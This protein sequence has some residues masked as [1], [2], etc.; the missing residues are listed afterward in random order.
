MNP[1]PFVSLNHFTLPVFRMLFCSLFLWPETERDLIRTRPLSKF[2]ALTPG[3]TNRWH[4][5]R[6]GPYAVWH[7]MSRAEDDGAG[8]RQSRGRLSRSA[9]FPRALIPRPLLA[10]PTG[11]GPP[12]SCSLRMENDV[13][14]DDGAR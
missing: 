4:L 5:G 2:L 12:P 9:T 13:A 7:R 6:G 1:K 3:G 8:T 11:E 14:L 10:S